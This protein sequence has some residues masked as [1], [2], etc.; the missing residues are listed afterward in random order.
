MITQS[1]QEEI[2]VNLAQLER[3]GENYRGSAWGKTKMDRVFGFLSQ[4]IDFESGTNNVLDLGC[5]G[6][7][8]AKELEK[9]PSFNVVGVDLVV[10]LLRTLAK[11][12]APNIPLVAGDIEF[13]PIKDNTF[14]LIIHNQVLHHFFIRDL[15]LAEAKRILKPGGILF[16]IETNGWNPYV[17]Y[18]HHSLKSKKKNF[19]GDNE[20]PFSQ[21]KFNK[22]LEAAGMKILDS[23]MINFDFIK[24]LA[25]FDALFGKIPVF[26][27]VFG[28]SMVVCSQ[29]PG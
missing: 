1:K 10:E 9:I 7:T 8:L 3:E 2:Q 24:A 15:V 18:W 27:L 14:D 4:F 26:N 13:L 25:P 5:G 11:K 29:K 17:Y 16:S 22:E 12:R 20:N 21:P 28:G 23:K 6:M 19:I